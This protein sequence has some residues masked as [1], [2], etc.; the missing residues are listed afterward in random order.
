MELVETSPTH[1]PHDGTGQIITDDTI[2]TPS[3]TLP[4][5]FKVTWVLQALSSTA[6]VFVAMGFWFFEYNPE[7]SKLH[8][9]T[10]HVHAV[11][12]ILS[13]A[14]FMIVA[15]TCRILHFVYASLYFAFYVV[16]TLIYYHS[17]GSNPYGG[18]EMYE[19]MIDWEDGVGVSALMCFLIVF[20]FAPVI[21]AL[22]Y[23]LYLLRRVVAGEISVSC[24]C[25]CFNS[26]RKN[27]SV[28]VE[29][30]VGNGRPRS[31]EFRKLSEGADGNCPNDCWK[32]GPTLDLS[33]SEKI[34]MCW[35][36]ASVMCIN[37]FNNNIER[38]GAIYSANVPSLWWLLSYMHDASNDQYNL[39][40][41]IY[42]LLKYHL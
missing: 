33:L 36:P 15:N 18:R 22:Y 26:C 32:F 17:G 6:T 20:V 28:N 9:F 19:G 39:Y 8:V 29:K 5:Y 10:V 1:Q 27:R 31:E 2:S 14:D 24:R 13:I 3:Q 40:P 35:V 23:G 34:Y 41:L 16:F 37:Y 38:V 11:A 25:G 12:A 21:H 42:N 30:E 4:W 7:I